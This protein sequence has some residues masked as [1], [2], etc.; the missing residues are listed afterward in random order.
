MNDKYTHAVLFCLAV[1]TGVLNYY[2]LSLFVPPDAWFQLVLCA[3]TG[4]GVTLVVSLFWTYAFHVVPD[5]RT[6]SR[7]AGGWVTVVVGVLLI[8]AVSTYWNLIAI[9]G[10]EIARLASTDVVARAEIAM[11]NAVDASGLFNS[12]MS[13]VAAFS[14][15]VAD[16]IAVEVAGANSG[17]SGTGPISTSM[18]QIGD[19]LGNLTL[20]LSDGG[21]AIAALRSKG[22][23]CLAALNAASSSGDA[24]AIAAQVAC[25][26]GVIGDL[27]NQNMLS[28]IERGLKT[29]TD[30]IVLPATVNTDV[31]R[32]IIA[33][34]M[35]D[36][37]LRADQIATLVSAVEMPVV[38]PVS[39]E[40][41]NRM[42]GVLLHWKSIL[43]AI[44]TATAI[45]LLPLV[46]LVFR[47]LHGDDRRVR[48]EPTG[49]LNA[50]ELLD[51]LRQME[52]LKGK[53]P[54]E[55]PLS[56]PFVD[57]PDDEWFEDEAA[58]HDADRSEGSE[59]TD[60]PK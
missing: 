52:L 21:N 40:M 24:T 10:S 41:P 29:L 15:D 36:N 53:A 54:Q 35:A 9:A 44:A 46:L 45:D 27:A 51:A 19:R 49:D 31:Q 4:F 16:Q 32:A 57:L 5:L 37:Q 22:D 34:F 30:G 18:A 2:G 59:Q 7:R 3:M 12:F 50:R 6:P 8:L 13:D 14:G 25:A 39:A 26:N 33:N 1:L 11:A 20:A 60:A 47:T 58:V 23:Q 17:G 43:P 28:V 48:G 55:K 42:A 38:E 56:P